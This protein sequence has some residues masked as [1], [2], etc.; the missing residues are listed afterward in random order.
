M[1]TQP[2]PRV[3]A[4]YLRVSSTQQ[5]TD[6]KTSLSTQEAECRAAAAAQGLIIAEAHVYRETC[7]AEDYYERPVLLE[8]RAAAGRGAFGVVLVHAVDRL[9][10]DPNHL[11]V[12]LA[13]LERAGTEVRF[14]IDSLEDTPEGRLIAYVKGYAAQME[15]RMRKERTLRAKRARVAKGHLLPSNRPLY[16]YQWGPER[17]ERGRLVKQRMLPDPVTAPIVER[18]FTEAASGKTLRAIAAALSSEGIPTPATYVGQKNGAKAWDPAVVA[19][20]LSHPTYWGEPRAFTTKAVHLTP[21]ERARRGYKHRVVRITRPRD[22]QVDLP[23]TVAPPLV[24]REVAAEVVRRLLMNRAF[25]SRNNR[26]P[27]DTLLHGGFAHCGYCGGVLTVTGTSRRHTDGT[28]ASNYQCKRPLRVKGSCATFTIKTHLVDAG[29]WDAIRALL[30]D[31][32][33]IAY[34]LERHRDE[35]SQTPA[36]AALCA[37]DARLADLTRRMQNKRKLAELIDDDD[38]RAD[39]AEELTALRQ[40]QRDMEREREV[41][42][43]H[44]TRAESQTHALQR[45]QDWAANVAPRV[46][47]LTMRERREVLAALGATVRVWRVGDREPRVALDLH[48]PVSGVL[49]VL[50]EPDGSTSICVTMVTGKI[51]KF[52]MRKASIDEWGLHSAAGVHTA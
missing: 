20:M 35:P 41:A 42:A 34:E 18:L 44:A 5:A 22:E 43:L 10:R 48:L 47:D 4:L 51:Q 2:L 19:H 24:T 12:A 50:R 40:Q 38:E 46:D 7:T 26:H 31:P 25:A 28:P 27:D 33:L 14:A 21:Q 11:L 52:I 17:D 1:S 3:A 37:I 36:Q 9:S 49:P 45:I 6:D 39:L 15:N 16:G 30:L 13:E 32:R 23:A 8:V 29:V